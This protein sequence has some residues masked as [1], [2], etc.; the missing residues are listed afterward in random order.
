MGI[1]QV[2]IKRAAEEVARKL[3]PAG[4]F[5]VKSAAAPFTSP[6]TNRSFYPGDFIPKHEMTA[7]FASSKAAAL[8]TVVRTYEYQF[9]EANFE[10]AGSGNYFSLFTLAAGWVIRRATVIIDTAFTNNLTVTARVSGS[11][12]TAALKTSDVVIVSAAKAAGTYNITPAGSVAYSFVA[13]SEVG[14][15]LKEATS[16]GTAGVMRVRIEAVQAQVL[17]STTLDYSNADVAKAVGTLTAGCYPV[18][19]CVNVATGFSG[20]DGVENLEIGV[21]A[22]HQLV[23]VV[24]GADLTVGADVYISS[25]ISEALTESKAI[26]AILN[27]V[28]PASPPTAGAITVYVLGVAPFESGSQFGAGLVEDTSEIRAPYSTGTDQAAPGNGA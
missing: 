26:V 9:T 14:I 27:S 10:T 24:G 2:K 11:G 1:N 13:D 8:D 3:K 25:N 16:V 6:E 23:G 15:F 22:S 12:G 4:S 20:G 28:T 19:Y 21:S 18:A 17:V 7:G 5:K